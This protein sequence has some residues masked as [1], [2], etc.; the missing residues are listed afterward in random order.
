VYRVVEATP[1]IRDLLVGERE[2][3]LVLPERVEPP[4][5]EAVSVVIIDTGIAPE[6]PLL[7]PA[8]RSPGISVI[9]GD[10]SPVDV[11]GHGTEVAGLA[12]YSDLGGQLL[13]GGQ[14]RPR[15]GS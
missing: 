13:D 9:V 10:P 14:V 6:H 7:A 8:L 2:A 15:V 11:H 12:A 4:G 5:D 1:P 3:E